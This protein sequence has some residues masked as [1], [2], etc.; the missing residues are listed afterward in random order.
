LPGQFERALERFGYEDLKA[1]CAPAKLEGPLSASASVASSN[2]ASAMEYARLEVDNAGQVV[3]Y[4]A[5]T[6][7]PGHRDG[8]SQIVP[9]AAGLH[10]RRS[11]G[12]WRYP[13]SYGNAAT[14]AVPP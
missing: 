8:A 3:L 5:A 2:Q 13:S 9:I 4:S 1:T 12:A 6:R 10:R 7:S 11:R 14:L